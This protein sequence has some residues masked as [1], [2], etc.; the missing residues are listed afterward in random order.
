MVAEVELNWH[1]QNSFLS[2]VCIGTTPFWKNESDVIADVTDTDVPGTVVIPVRLCLWM[3]PE[4]TKS[5]AAV[6]G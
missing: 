6:H 3:I 4:T 5:V 1:R 2:L